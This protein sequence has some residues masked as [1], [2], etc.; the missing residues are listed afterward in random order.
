LNWLPHYFKHMK[1][2]HDIFHGF[3]HVCSE[4]CFRLAQR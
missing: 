3:S 1:K 2:F 4:S